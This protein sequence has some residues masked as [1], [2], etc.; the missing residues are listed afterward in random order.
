MY[1]TQNSKSH[2]NNQNQNDVKLN[3]YTGYP[4]DYM[5]NKKEIENFSNDLKY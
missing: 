5:T 1:E 4:K 2:S 3:I